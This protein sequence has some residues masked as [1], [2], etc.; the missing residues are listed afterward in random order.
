MALRVTQEMTLARSFSSISIELG[1]SGD[2]FHSS[3]FVETSPFE[4]RER[5]SILSPVSVASAMAESGRPPT[6]SASLTTYCRTSRRLVCR[7]VGPLVYS[8]AN[9]RWPVGPH[10]PTHLS[11]RDISC[12]FVSG[13]QDNVPRAGGSSDMD[14]RIR[15]RTG[16]ATRVLTSDQDISSSSS[17]LLLFVPRCGVVL[18]AGFAEL[19]RPSRQNVFQPSAVVS[20]G[21]W[22]VS[23]TPMFIS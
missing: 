11:R 22:G 23:G 8:E 2:T 1:T 18:F 7:S 13:G 5:T 12:A 20:S 3:H 9:L 21:D 4:L 16:R 14:S 10:R 17:I 15:R 6:L 19:N